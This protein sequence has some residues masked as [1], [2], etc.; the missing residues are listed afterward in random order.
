MMMKTED[1]PSPKPRTGSRSGLPMKNR[2]WRQVHIV[3]RD[4][5][6]SL[7]FSPNIGF[8]TVGIRV[9]G[10]TRW[11]QPTWARLEGA[12]PSGLC[13]PKCSPLVVPG[14]RNSLL[15]YK[16]SLQKMKARGP[17]TCPR[18]WGRACPP[19]ARPLSPGPPGGPPASI[20]CY[21]I[22]FPLEKIVGK[23]TGGNS[24]ATR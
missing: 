9:C 4:E 11:G 10:A 8:Y 17:T 15:L 6:F 3:K 13:P 5:T 1:S 23:L 2:R 18:G 22:T 20:F 14:S 21:I 12:R 7:I 16:K 19:R 24:A